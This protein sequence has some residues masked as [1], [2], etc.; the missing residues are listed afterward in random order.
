MLLKLYSALSTKCNKK[1]GKV[2]RCAVYSQS[3]EI[4]FR[5]SRLLYSTY[6][7][8]PQ[9]RVGFLMKIAFLLAP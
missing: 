2:V 6:V 8:T 5:L 9:Y 4:I 1:G 3:G 7:P